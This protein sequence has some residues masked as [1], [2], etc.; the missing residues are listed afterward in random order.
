MD[1]GKIGVLVGLIGSILA[2]VLYAL[3]LRGNRKVLL[4]ARS[5]FAMTVFSAVFTFA[6]LMW[7]VY[8]RQFQYKYVFEYSDVT[9]HF[10]WNIAASWAG[11]EGS[12]VLWAFWTAIIGGLVA[13]KA[14][15]WESRVMPI[16]VSV[17]CF[18]FGI[19]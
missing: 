10:P 17:L 6:R 19:L 16:Y 9:L 12:F 4:A 2:V 15:K 7:I 18:L 13:W 1:I 5:A 14:G 11:Q 3:S 8:H